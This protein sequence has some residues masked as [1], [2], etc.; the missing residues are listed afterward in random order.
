M[1]TTEKTCTKCREVKPL[2]LF[3]GCKREKDGTRSVCKVCWNAFCKAYHL[4]HREKRMQRMRDYCDKHRERI[5]A[6]QAEYR[7]ENRESRLAA[8]KTDR[9]RALNRERKRKEYERRG[10][11]LNARVKARS[12]RP[13]VRAKIREYN[14]HP[15]R[16]LHSNV[17]RAIR[18]AIG[19]SKD[20]RKWEL[21]VGYTRAELTAHLESQFQPGMTWEN[22]GVGGWEI[23]HIRPQAS[24]SFTTPEDAQFKEC[25][26]LSNLQPL[27]MPDNRSK[28]A[29]TE[30]K[31]G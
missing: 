16:K 17:S 3:A 23:D 2:D 15:Q 5:R 27:W 7:R 28:W 20:G 4:K 9:A 18:T 24:F 26:A 31:A 30:D 19:L 14:S 11:I 10:D 1:E 12:K 6:Q 29:H 21:L 13:E 25:W 22:Y 8:N